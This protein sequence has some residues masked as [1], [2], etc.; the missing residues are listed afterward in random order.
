MTGGKGDV[1]A[2]TAA[3]GLIR[4]LDELDLAH[5]GGFWHANGQTLPW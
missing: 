4:R 3:A 5:S 2:E 1:A